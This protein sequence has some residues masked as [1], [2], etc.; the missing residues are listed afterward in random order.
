MVM[1]VSANVSL[2]GTDTTVLTGV[3]AIVTGLSHVTRPQGNVPARQAGKVFPATLNAQTLAGDP[4]V[5]NHVNATFMGHV[6]KIQGRVSVTLVIR[7]INV[8]RCVTLDILD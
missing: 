4:I 8:K 7:E 5:S 3:V 6:T 2:G 1:D